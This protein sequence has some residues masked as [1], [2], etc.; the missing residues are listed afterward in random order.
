M[1][2]KTIF[3]IKNNCKNLLKRSVMSS[4]VGAANLLPKFNFVSSLFKALLS[5]NKISLSQQSS[6]LSD[7]QCFR[8]LFTTQHSRIISKIS[9]AHRSWAFLL[10]YND[11]NLEPTKSSKCRLLNS[12]CEFFSLSQ[13]SCNTLRTEDATSAFTDNC[14]TASVSILCSQ[15]LRLDHA[16]SREDTRHIFCQLVFN[17]QRRLKWGD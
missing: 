17:L 6:L 4:E 5:G 2:N 12:G 9:E 1:S 8:F 10:E 11:R 14:S 13:A 15:F 7:W 16:S 3:V